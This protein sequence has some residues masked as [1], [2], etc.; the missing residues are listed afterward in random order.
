MKTIKINHQVTSLNWEGTNLEIRG[1]QTFTLYIENN[2]IIFY[3]VEDNYENSMLHN[4]N[5]ISWKIQPFDLV[6]QILKKG[7]NEVSGLKL[8]KRA[9]KLKELKKLGEKIP[10]FIEKYRRTY[11]SA[12]ISKKLPEKIYLFR[13]STWG[14]QGAW[15]HPHAEEYLNKLDMAGVPYAIEAV[16]D[17]KVYN[18]YDEYVVLNRKNF[19]A[20]HDHIGRNILTHKSGLKIVKPGHGYAGHLTQIE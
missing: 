8:A 3:E 5:E 7:H 15:V 16:E 20:H 4:S 6:G 2:I 18:K 13:C 11:F 14:N 17:S 10:N 1:T 12:P 9:T 19:F